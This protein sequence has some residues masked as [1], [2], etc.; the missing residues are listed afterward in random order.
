MT[1]GEESLNEGKY[2]IIGFESP[3]IKAWLNGTFIDFNYLEQQVVT[4]SHHISVINVLTESQAFL[5]EVKDIF[6]RK[7]F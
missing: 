5:V 6:A 3:S 7:A 4:W 2:R 1:S